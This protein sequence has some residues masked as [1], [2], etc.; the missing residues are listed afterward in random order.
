MPES[1]ETPLDFEPAVAEM[2]RLKAYLD[3]LNAKWQAIL[4]EQGI[5]EEKKERRRRRR[6]V[7]VYSGMPPW[8]LG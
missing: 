6:P 1:P 2:L 7:R 4:A 8:A 5:V 3:A